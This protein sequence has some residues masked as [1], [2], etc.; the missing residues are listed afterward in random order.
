ME[1]QLQNQENTQQQVENLNEVIKQK[2]TE[3]NKL[4]AL[5]Q[6]YQRL[7][8]D[9]RKLREERRKLLELQKEEAK[10][11]YWEIQEKQVQKAMKKLVEE[12]PEAKDKE[13]QILSTFQKLGSESIDF[14]EIYRDLQKSYMV[15]DYDNVLKKLAETQE[16]TSAVQQQLVQQSSASVSGV[17]T[18]STEGL[19][20]LEMELVQ[21]LNKT[22]QEAKEISQKIKSGKTYF[23]KPEL[24]E[25]L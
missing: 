16:K 3:L 23:S 1:E 7:I 12:F 6:E 22:P 9:I 4:S 2:E 25:T 8:D 20:P 17:S 11:V 14:D 10:S 5:S 15:V 19:S 24:E 13:E 21:K 18:T